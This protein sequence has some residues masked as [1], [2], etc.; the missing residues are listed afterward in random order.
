MLVTFGTFWAGEGIG[1]DW[2]GGDAVLF[3]LLAAYVGASL[4]GVWA[5][6]AMLRGRRAAV[7]VALVD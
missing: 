5:V 6:H 1:I 2:P 4:V 7:T 3:V